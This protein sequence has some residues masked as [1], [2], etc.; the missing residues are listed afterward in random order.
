MA[1]SSRQGLS[2]EDEKL[3]VGGMDKRL[4]TALWNV[5]LSRLFGQLSANSYGLIVQ[6]YHI[7]IAVWKNFFCL[8]MDELSKE[9]RERRDEFRDFFE[10]ADWFRIYDLLEFVAER[11]TAHDAELWREECNA[12]LEAENSGYRL[13]GF[14]VIPLHS[15]PISEGLQH[16]LDLLLAH[17]LKR[18]QQLFA[19][20]HTSPWAETSAGK[21]DSTLGEDEVKTFQEAIHEALDCAYRELFQF[22]QPASNLDSALSEGL[23]NTELKVPR[24]VAQTLALVHSSLKDTEL[25]KRSP[26][27]RQWVHHQALLGVTTLLQLYVEGG[28][29]EAKERC[30]HEATVQDPWGERRVGK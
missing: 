24:G 15:A 20:A 25:L 26:T 28:L 23:K 6:E 12:A 17:G 4:R 9:L 2:P 1:F 19:S 18:S 21:D 16:A 22:E 5:V 27:S 8:P 13:V 11:M 3:Q 7:F 29:R 10:V 14:Q 30:A